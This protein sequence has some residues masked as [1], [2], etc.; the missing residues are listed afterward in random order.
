[1]RK[2]LLTGALLLIF[3]FLLSGCA[4]MKEK[5]EGIITNT[6]QKESGLEDDADYKQYLNYKEGN[7]LTEDNVPIDT[8]EEEEHHGTIHVT[9]GE[10]NHISIIYY[11]DENCTRE[12]DVNNCYINPGDSIYYSTLLLDDTSKSISNM[13]SFTGFKVYQHEKSEMKEVSLEGKGSNC[14]LSVP[15]DSTITDLSVFP[16][17][18]YENRPLNCTAYYMDNGVK[19]EMNAVIWYVDINHQRYAI[20][21]NPVVGPTDD[22]TIIADLSNYS[23]FYALEENNQLVNGNEVAFRKCSDAKTAQNNFELQLYKYIKFTME[24]K[25]SYKSAVI[26][27]LLNSKE[28]TADNITQVKPGDKIVIQL[29]EEYGLKDLTGGLK[30]GEGATLGDKV[31]EYTVVIPEGEYAEYGLQIVKKSEATVGHQ[32]KSVNNMTIVLFKPD[33][34]ILKAGDS[35]DNDV[36]V[37]VQIKGV[38]DYYIDGTDAS[39]GIYEKKMKYQ[40]Y[41]SNIDTILSKLKTVKYCTVKLVTDDPHGTVIYTLGDVEYTE[42]ATIRVRHGQKIKMQYTLTDSEFKYKREGWNP[43]N[44]MPGPKK[45]VD[46]E[47]SGDMT[48]VPSNYIELIKK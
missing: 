20:E 33:G 27:I 48:I 8:D 5:A 31:V 19:K 10:N 7:Q 22:F 4:S 11:Y 26:K 40:E 1:M 32:P 18:K 36:K 44:Y 2:H 41:T 16:L 12:V 15:S 17:G 29:N 46:V 34:S 38:G 9:F 35:I 6:I 23:N 37:T 39:N 24:V 3:L 14:V 13:Y 28:T 45:T 42:E 30:F 25:K 43:L 21:D 47:V